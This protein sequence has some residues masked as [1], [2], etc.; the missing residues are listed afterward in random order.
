MTASST[1]QPF[2]CAS[3]LSLSPKVERG[4][5]EVCDR[6]LAALDS[7]P[8]L[9][10]LFVSSDGIQD[11]PDL[12]EQ[13]CDRLGTECLIGCTAES[14]VGT[15]REI[16]GQTAVSLWLARLPGASAIPMHLTFEPTSEGGSLLGWPDAL[17]EAWPSPASLLVLGEPF[18]FPA[19]FLL[20]RLNEEHPGVAVI[21]GMA[22]A[23][24]APG[25]N[26]VLCGRRTLDAGAAAILLSG[27]VGVRPLVSQ[28]CRPI[29]DPF[30]ITKAERNVIYELGGVPAVVQL[31]NLLISLPTHEQDMVR[32]GLHLGRVVNEY[33]EH[34]E[35]GDFLIRNVLGIDPESGAIIIGDYVR[36]GQTVK[37]HLRDWQ[38]ADADLRQMLAAVRKSGGAPGGALLFTCNG[39]GTRL[40]PE[41]HHDALAI[42]EVLGD[43]PVAGFFAAGELGPVGG[44]NFMHG[45]TA[46]IALFEDPTGQGE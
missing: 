2:R 21:G 24:A 29:G 3:A 22:S 34:F 37:F 25:E 16:E 20:E 32:R 9:A 26:R 23:G 11:W 4:L 8:S 30:V 38:S 46:S 44:R 1:R 40:F 17:L 15:G 28:G 39:R 7:V 36:V 31:H 6:A 10:V 12:A 43:I 14:V 33:Q 42:R 27:P 5:A 45:F 35:Y 18:S 13:A 19:D 41:P